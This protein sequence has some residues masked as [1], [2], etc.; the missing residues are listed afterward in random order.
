MY[1]IFLPNFASLTFL[2]VAQKFP[3]VCNRK[4]MHGIDINRVTQVPK[5][6]KKCNISPSKK[7][8]TL[9]MKLSHTLKSCPQY[10]L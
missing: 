7:K 3:P 10:I 4:V 1:D 8:V 2:S 5:N 6:F 9:K